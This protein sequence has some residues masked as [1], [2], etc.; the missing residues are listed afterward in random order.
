MNR[1][2]SVVSLSAALA[3]SLFMSPAVL[4][5]SNTHNQHVSST[6]SFSSEAKEALALSRKAIDLVRKNKISK[7][8]DYVARA[9]N[10]CKKIE[11]FKKNRF[12]D[13]FQI[14]QCISCTYFLL[15]QYAI[16]YIHK[17]RKE[18]PSANETKQLSSL[19]KSLQPLE[20]SLRQFEKQVDQ[21]RDEMSKELKQKSKHKAIPTM[22]VKHTKKILELINEQEQQAKGFA[23]KLLTM[24]EQQ[25][26]ENATEHSA[27]RQ[28]FP[29]N[30]QFHTFAPQ[31]AANIALH[32]FEEVSKCVRK[33]NS[34]EL[35]AE[36]TK[37]QNASKQLKQITKKKQ[38][39]H[40]NSAHSIQQ[41]ISNTYSLADHYAIH[42]TYKAKSFFDA[43]QNAVYPELHENI[44]QF[45]NIN[46]QIE[47]LRKSMTSEVD[48]LK[49]FKGTKLVSKLTENTSTQVAHTQQL[50]NLVNEQKEQLKQLAKKWIVLEQQ[51]LDNV[52]N[53]E[54]AGASDLKKDGMKSIIQCA[55]TKSEQL[56]VDE[57]LA[58]NDPSTYF[59]SLSEW[60][61]I[62]SGSSSSNDISEISEKQRVLDL[63]D[64]DLS[65]PLPEQQTL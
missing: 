47:E 61:A 63:Y 50:L 23:K 48:A 35:A 9:D 46:N 64:T 37:V 4:A 42:Y 55:K 25:S 21:L 49:K 57:F 8:E 29:N 17:I 26:V 22:Q 38:G 2:P 15:D 53:Q 56:S 5:Q 30:S 11:Q 18:I 33:E 58:S 14:E 24:P 20:Q 54:M 31:R 13:K 16:E 62:I 39:S 19:N 41:S 44:Q 3:V 6:G 10:A 59:T 51:K 32:L 1:N 60:S 34:S 43:A 36:L 65:L 45:K 27:K 7:I 40:V 12:M 52:I 28:S